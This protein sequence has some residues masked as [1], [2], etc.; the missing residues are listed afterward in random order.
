[1]T[2]AVKY[3][4][5]IVFGPTGAVGGQLALEAS[6]RD[7]KVWLAMRSPEKFIEGISKDEEQQGS[8]ER[9]QADLS[10]PDSV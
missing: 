3:D 10:D 2:V 1:L 8:F 4:N 7:A 6:K 9:I 5:V